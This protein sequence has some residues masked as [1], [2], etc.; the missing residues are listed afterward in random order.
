LPALPFSIAAILSPERAATIIPFSKASPRRA[1]A[2]LGDDEHPAAA[3]FSPAYRVNPIPKSCGL[4]R[5]EIM[6][7]NTNGSKVR[8]AIASA[9][10]L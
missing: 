10:A 9:F 5:I 2:S 8:D 7:Q 1:G 4:F 3:V 6:R